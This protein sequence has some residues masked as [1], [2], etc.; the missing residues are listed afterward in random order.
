[1]ATDDDV[2][3]PP[4]GLARG[5]G[6]RIGGGEREVVH[7]RL[8]C[9]VGRHGPRTGRQERQVGFEHSLPVRAPRDVVEDACR[10]APSSARTRR[11][12]IAHRPPGRRPRASPAPRDGR[13]GGRSARPAPPRSR[14]GTISAFWPS[15][16]T[17]SRPSASV[18]TIGF[19]AAS[20]SNTVSGVPS[21]SDG[22]TDRSNAESSRATSRTNPAKTNRSPRPSR[23]ACSSSAGRSGPSPA[24]HESR[25]RALVHHLASRLDQVIVA[26]GVVQ[27]RH[28]ADDEVTL[29]RT[30][31]ATDLGDLRR[32]PRPA[33]LVERRAQVDDL[34]LPGRHACARARRTP[35][36]SRRRLW[37]CR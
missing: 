15:V 25:V 24:R 35:R 29:R 28:R 26:L 9:H 2:K 23:R 22:N 37:R 17:S 16:S 4:D 13:S 11:C 33:E 1:M 10:G 34:H 36:C 6:G 12:R 31:L 7:G 21:Q 19:P 20:V 14:F 5:Y 32:V 27:A 8:V 3:A 18:A 30:E